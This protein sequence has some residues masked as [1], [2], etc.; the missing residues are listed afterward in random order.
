MRSMRMSDRE[1]TKEQSIDLLKRGEYGILSTIDS[2]N[3]PYGV[4]LSYAYAD[5]LLYFHGAKEGTKLD[6]IINNN[7]VCFTVVGKTNVLPEKFSTKYESVIVF[8]KGVIVTGDEKVK[9]LREIIRKYS[10]EFFSQGEEYIERAKDKTTVIKIE[11][12][13]FSGKHSI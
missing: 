2:E 7:S 4:P 9:G 10:P 12:I 3:N 11:I 13:D 1:M 6:N 8:G 5:N